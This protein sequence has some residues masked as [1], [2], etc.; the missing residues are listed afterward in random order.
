MAVLVELKSGRF[1]LL[2]YHTQK[3]GA[4]ETPTAAG[5]SPN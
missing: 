1:C 2:S 4:N 3:G 5:F